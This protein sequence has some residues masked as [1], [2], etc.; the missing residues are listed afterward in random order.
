MSAKLREK[1]VTQ[2]RPKPEDVRRLIEALEELHGRPRFV[3]RF[4]PME[5]L[6]SCI[7]SQHSAD[8]NSFPAF[9][10]LRSTYP[11]WEVVAALPESELA[12]V[13]RK[14]GLANQKARSIKASL[15]AIHDAT[16][17]YS[18]E[19]LRSM[20]LDA[21]RTW[22]LKL[23][24]VGPKTAA[25][26]LCFAFGRHAI[27]VDT[28]VHRVGVRLG[29]IPFGMDE[30]K[31]HDWTLEV[32]PEDMAFRFHVTLIQHGRK[33][34]RAPKPLC[35]N[36]PVTDSCLAFRKQDFAT[37]PGKVKPRAK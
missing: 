2:R 18:L 16:G 25:I 33:V 30:N 14:A 6:V 34:C 9:M 23:P 37:K 26:V 8:A 17:E 4:D 28:H 31:A 5:E 19:H 11:D 24:G 36:C 10:K 32:V 3:N 29:L 15:K 27:P 12:D 1:K 21:A 22:L 13:I 35:Q 20:T 7:L